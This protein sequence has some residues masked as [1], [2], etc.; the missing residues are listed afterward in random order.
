MLT[1]KMLKA[2]NIEDE[3]IEQII[4]AHTETVDALK[5]D[6]GISAIC[7]TVVVDDTGFDDE[8][9]QIALGLVGEGVEELY[10][11][12]GYPEFQDYG[13]VKDRGDHGEPPP[14][15]EEGGG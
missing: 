12:I 11:A 5:H 15:P 1:R 7:P 13:P 9:Y 2:M 6:F 4:E 14:L 3:K 8:K 10:K